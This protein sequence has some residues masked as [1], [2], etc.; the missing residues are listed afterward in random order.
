MQQSF[1]A[2]QVIKEET[3]EKEHQ[4]RACVTNFVK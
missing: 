2:Q 3:E 4:T 1:E